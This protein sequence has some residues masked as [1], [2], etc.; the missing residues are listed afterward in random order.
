[1]SVKECATLAERL[2]DIADAVRATR[3]PDADL[4]VVVAETR[5][6]AKSRTVTPTVCRVRGRAG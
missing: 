2:D 6:A 5:L 1:M 3:L 4:G